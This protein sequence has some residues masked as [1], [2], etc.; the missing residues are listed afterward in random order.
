MNDP[1]PEIVAVLNALFPPALAGP[2]M[3]VLFIWILRR[4]PRRTLRY[5][6]ILLPLVNLLVM[7]WV[8]IT[9]D[10]F[11]GSGSVACFLTP[12]ATIVSGLV[13]LVARKRIVSAIEDD[14]GKQRAYQLGLLVIPLLPLLCMGIVML[15]A[16]AM[17]EWGVRECSDW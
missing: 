15:F 10:G 12:I 14:L 6:W 9:L 8:S 3:S 7:V 5:F 2:V 13:L 17:C 16:P 11:F 1:T 4:G